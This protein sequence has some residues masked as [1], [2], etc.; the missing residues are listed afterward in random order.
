MHPKSGINYWHVYED[1]WH[2]LLNNC[3]YF[4]DH[5][6]GLPLIFST[7]PSAQARVPLFTVCVGICHHQH[8]LAW[9]INQ[10][11]SA[12]R[13][14]QFPTL[15]LLIAILCLVDKI[16]K[17]KTHLLNHD[18]HV[19]GCKKAYPVKQRC[20]QWW[21]KWKGWK[22]Q[23]LNI[24]RALGFSFFFKILFTGKEGEVV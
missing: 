14:K 22:S 7:G 10:S 3:C 21:W 18:Q 12:W 2:I 15:T 23:S 5:F 20:W 19:R 9:L 11:S 4:N 24:L 6:K 8:F 16:L 17:S 13:F 1:Y